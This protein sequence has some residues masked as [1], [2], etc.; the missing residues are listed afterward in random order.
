MSFASPNE[1]KN[2]SLLVAVKYKSAVLA[3]PDVQ[4]S[5]M[6]VVFARP[7][8]TPFAD[9]PATAGIEVVVLLHQTTVAISVGEP[10]R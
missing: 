1:G 4:T 6:A 9:H 3:A 7:L 8:P 5:S 2:Q 10:S